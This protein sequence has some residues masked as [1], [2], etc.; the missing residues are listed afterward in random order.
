MGINIKFIFLNAFSQI[1]ENYFWIIVLVFIGAIVVYF[2]RHAIASE[3]QLTRREKSR[4]TEKVLLISI[5][6]GFATIIYLYVK[7]YYFLLSVVMS[8]ILTY[9]LYLIGLFDIV[10]EKLENK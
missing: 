4:L 3:L 6:I 2:F 8:F 1:F 9:F 10:I 5:L 7:E